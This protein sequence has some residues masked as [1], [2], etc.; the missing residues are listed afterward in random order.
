[1][2]PQRTL[3]GA[4][5]GNRLP[6]GHLSP[7]LRG[8]VIGSQRAG[9]TPAEIALG[10]N[11]YRQTIQYTLAQAKL[12]TNGESLSRLPRSESYTDKEERYILRYVRLHPKA[13]YQDVKQELGVTCSTSTLKRILKTHG[14]SNWR[15]KRRPFV[16]DIVA[17][18]RLA[19]CLARSHWTTEEWGCVMWSDECSVERGRGKNQ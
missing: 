8:Q 15:A 17:A 12:R 13:T 10:L 11:L 14:I 4:I 1:M 5:S 19:W 6:G 3:L 18:K 7:Y 16:T 2:P 9:A